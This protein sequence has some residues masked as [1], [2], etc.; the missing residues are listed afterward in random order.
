VLVRVRR[1]SAPGELLGD[2]RTGAKGGQQEVCEYGTTRLVDFA[3]NN[4]DRRT[5]QDRIRPGSGP[6]LRYLDAEW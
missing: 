1:G 2:D 3:P 4:L 5:A 6:P